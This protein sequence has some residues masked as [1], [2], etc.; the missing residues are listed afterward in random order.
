[1]ERNLNIKN[2]WTLDETWSSGTG[3]HKLEKFKRLLSKGK[4]VTGRV[5]RRRTRSDLYLIKIT[6]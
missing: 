4:V 5:T 1:M 3:N 6:R 2:V